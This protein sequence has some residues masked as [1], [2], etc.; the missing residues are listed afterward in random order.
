MLTLNWLFRLI[1]DTILVGFVNRSPFL[2]LSI[3]AF[4]VLGLVI[5]AVQVATPFIYTLF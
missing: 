5:T 2:A 3:L 4:L 1:K